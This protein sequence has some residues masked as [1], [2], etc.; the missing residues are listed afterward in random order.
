MNKTEHYALS[1]KQ[2]WAALMVHRLKTIEVSRWPTAR[3]GRIFIHADRV[4]D[5]RP[6]AWK[7]I[8]KELE[9]AA[10]LLGGIIGEA[11]LT[12]CLI[13]RTLDA[14]KKDQPRHLNEPDW[15]ESPVLYGFNF[16]NAVVLP[17]R[18]YPGWMRFFP[19]PEGPF[20]GRKPR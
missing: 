15:F 4:P 19:V 1:I 5:S 17:F 10:H 16:A 6:E 12:G 3:R 18:Q 8:P 13:Y 2:P 11:D 9:E 20:K 7:H 14:F